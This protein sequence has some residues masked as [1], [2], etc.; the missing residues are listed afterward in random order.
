M[1]MLMFRAFFF[2]LVSFYLILPD[3]KVRPLAVALTHACAMFFHELAVFFFPVVILGIIFQTVNEEKIKKRFL[4]IAVY[5]GGVFLLTFATYCICFYLQN[6]SFD[7]PGFVRWVTF[8]TTENGFSQQELSNLQLTIRGNRQLFFNGSAGFQP[9]DVTNI[10]LLI[11]FAVSVIIFL[12]QSARNFRDI[13]TV[14]RKLRE[15]KAYLQPVSLLC[16]V[17][18][19]P[20][21]L[22]L[23]YFIPAN[24][25]YRLFYF[26]A[27]IIL[28][29][30]WLAPFET[31]NPVRRWRLAFFVLIVG[32][33]NFLFF[34]RPQSQIRENTPL[35]LATQANKIW[36]PKTVVY[37]ELLD[38]DNRII[39]YFTPA[40]VWKPVDSVSPEE[41]K[42]SVKTIYQNGGTAWLELS[43]FKKFSQSPETA[44]LLTGDASRESILELNTAGA[45][46]RYVQLAPP[47]EK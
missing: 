24:T 22:F 3:K 12:I 29:G 5:T 35:A 20:Y 46:V 8:Y 25:F 1:P 37:F 11:F 45:N 42:E 43:A 39:K 7:I 30:V 36:T 6:E 41:F 16:L 27:L 2:L 18:V 9:R 47:A 38:T 19:A 4:K 34:I 21:L 17:W 13:Q 33:S 14:W 31:L 28:A 40:A 32:L 15:D 26:P 23:F 44:W 10:I